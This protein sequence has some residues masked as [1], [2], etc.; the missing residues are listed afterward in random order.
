M[1]R[2]MIAIMLGL[3]IL[4]FFPASPVAAQDSSDRPVVTISTYTPNKTP[5]RGESFNLSVIF[6]NSGQRPAYNMLIE[7]VSGDLFP[8]GNGG[9]QSIYQLIM[10]ESKGI[11]QGFTVSPDLWGASIASVTVNLEYSDDQG[12]SFSDSFT[13]TIDL[14][15]AAYVAPSATPT[16]TAVVQP[17]L[18][19]T[20][21][22]TD[23]SIL[24]PGTTFEL[25]LDVTNLGNG[26]AKA[27]SMV[28]GGGGVEMN[29]EGTPQPGISGGEGEFG[30]FAPLDASNIVY[31]G[32][33]APGA[34]ISA[35]QKI[36]VNVSTAPGAYSLKYSFIYTTEL[37]EK[38][39][40]NQVITLLIYQLPVLEVGFYQDPGP[41]FMQQPNNLPLQVMNLGKKSVVLG[42]MEVTAEDAMIENGVALVGPVEA[43]FYFTLDSMIIPEQAGPMEL[44]IRINYTDDF[45]QP[46][47]YETT[48]P[49]EVIEAAVPPEG[50]PGAEGGMGEGFEGPIEGMPG[51]DSSMNGGGGMAGTETFWQKI[52]RVIKGL[53][54]LDSGLNTSD[55][56]GV[57]VDMPV[58]EQVPENAPVKGP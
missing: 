17:Q 27:M 44:Q 24:Q 28:L 49:I 31:L 50:L 30:N 52:V 6:H 57:P 14:Q 9:T 40:D 51:L 46:Q 37:G 19:I 15:G 11:N 47:V 21:Y 54:G 7:F 12:N 43:G 18:V 45:N 55:Q 35:S 48:V 22:E 16:P 58:I 41:L 29:P 36:I 13:L 1:K 53:F 5:A 34:S 10:D 23:V 38:V 42:N 32:D 33:L 20:S 39:V 56:M 25:A 4:A 8:R 2:I 3:S 26:P